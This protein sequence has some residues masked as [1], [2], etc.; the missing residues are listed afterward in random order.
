MGTRLAGTFVFWPIISV[1]VSASSTS[2]RMRGRKRILFHAFRF[3]SKPARSAVVEIGTVA[4]TVLVGRAARHVS[5]CLC[6][7]FDLRSRLV[8][9]RG[10]MGAFNQ[11]SETHV[12]IWQPNDL[13]QADLLLL[14]ICLSGFRLA[15]HFRQCLRVDQSDE[16]RAVETVFDS[17]R[18]VK[19]LED[20]RSI[21]ACRSVNRR[22]TARM[23]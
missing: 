19:R 11:E 9:S 15:E 17:S 1:V 7:E 12:E 5:P 14:L 22:S 20:G 10:M 2:T 13:R 16:G 23:S 8:V 4:L 21:V 3:R 6:C 18:W